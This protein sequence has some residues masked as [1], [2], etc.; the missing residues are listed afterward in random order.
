MLASNGPWNQNGQGQIDEE[1]VLLLV[2]I[3]RG[4][5]CSRREILRIPLLSLAPRNRQQQIVEVERSHSLPSL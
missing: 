3:Q 1:A 5:E 4:P 2:K